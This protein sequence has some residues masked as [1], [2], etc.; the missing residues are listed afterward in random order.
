MNRTT[1]NTETRRPASTPGMTREAVG[2]LAHLDE[3]DDYKVADGEP[4]VRGWRVKTADGR[5]I[6]KVED[7]LVDC[8][9]MQVRYLEV[10]LDRKALDLP[11]DRHVLLPVA[12]ARLND[13]DDVVLVR[14]GAAEFAGL[15][16]YARP[17]RGASAASTRGVGAPHAAARGDGATTMTRSEEELAV[18]TRRVEAG[19]VEV[20]KRV[21][22]ER[23][24]EA[25]PVT[26]EEATVERRPISADA[27][28]RGGQVRVG[29]NE[30][31]VP[32]MGEEV[33]AEKRA[34]PK[35]E[36]VVRKRAVQDERVVEADLR[37][38][39]VEVAG[40]AAAPPRPR[41]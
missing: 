40:D 7:L 14:A 25:V 11:E 30:I 2:R 28:A 22:T 21:E 35:E 3:L 6:G 1:A 12:D 20:R 15:P 8:G 39:R 9:L 24:R 19:A 26:R 36:I 34:V 29:E 31:R 18:G 32:L 16:A 37:R 38:E 27:A 5:T 4:D 41:R 13:D 33:V 23:V 10:E 17:P